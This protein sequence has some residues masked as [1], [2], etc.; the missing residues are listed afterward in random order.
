MPI[1]E[2]IWVTPAV[3]GDVAGPVIKTAI[4]VN[5]LVTALEK[6]QKGDDI[7]Q[8]LNDLR[9]KSNELNKIF[10]QLTGWKPE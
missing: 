8:E 1:T 2:D 3:K 6:M 7:S 4:A 5:A 9:E 10:D